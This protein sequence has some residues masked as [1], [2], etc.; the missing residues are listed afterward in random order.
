MMN[1]G[2]AFGQTNS[3][4]SSD[5][6]ASRI[7]T[8]KNSIVS[9]MDGSKAISTAVHSDTYKSYSTNYYPHFKYVYYKWEITDCNTKLKNVNLLFDFL[10]KSTPP[11]GNKH[12]V[13]VETPDLNSVVD[14]VDAGTT[15]ESYCPLITSN[16]NHNNSSVD[17]FN[18]TNTIYSPLQ[19]FNSGIAAKDVICRTDLQLIFKIENGYPACVN[20]DTA[21]KL[22]ER[23]WAKEI[24]P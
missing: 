11:C 6:C 1:A 22:I 10:F 18:K 3:S 7:N 5:D 20:P 2:T 14:V 19:Q 23:G 12:I 13:F 8:I 9:S 17:M 4:M 16:S 21:Q 15:Y 24:I